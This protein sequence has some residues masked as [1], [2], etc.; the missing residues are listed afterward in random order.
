MQEN[1]K[2]KFKNIFNSI[3]QEKT[4]KFEIISISFA[5]I[6]WFL[7]FS[8]VTKNL[9]PT[10]YLMLFATAALIFIGVSEFEKEILSSKKIFLGVFSAVFLYGVF[11][12]GNEISLWLFPFAKREIVNIYH[13]RSGYSEI[14]I[15]L[16]LLFWIGPAEE[17]FWRGFLQKRF[18]KRFGLKKG[19]TISTL[20]YV[21]IHVPSMNF[22]LVG[23]AFVA[24]VFW[25]WSYHRFNSIYI[26]I[27][28][29][30]IWDATIFVIF[31]IT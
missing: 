24:G 18:I 13:I 21:L 4:L 31:P 9:F 30:A 7:M 3:K 2:I 17:I 22:M 11:W 19:I 29:H 27:I 25:S 23:A 26:N 14:F 5:F 10:F 8:P 20:F 15:I 28:S 6:L 12:L 1:I 16:I